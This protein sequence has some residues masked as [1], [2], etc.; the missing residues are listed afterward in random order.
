MNDVKAEKGEY[1]LSTDKSMLDL[2]MI[3]EFLS[4]E[5]H[6]AK[7][8][9]YERVKKSIEN[10]L[11][12]GLYHNGV[13]IGFARVI[14]DYSTIAYLGDLFILKDHRGKGLSRWMLE[15]IMNHPDLTG[16]RRWILVTKDA[17][18]VYQQ[19]GWAMVARPE[20]WMEIHDP[21]AYS[22]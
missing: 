4:T 8:I 1:L 21:E 20:N 10:S 13:Q 14:S 22:N 3:H 7:N 5:S 19:Y 6:W 17:H 12:F 11:C 18:D 2:K 16:L 9:P 15:V